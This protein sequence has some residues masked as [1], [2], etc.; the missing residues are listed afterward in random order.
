MC[1]FPL[2]VR[3]DFLPICSWPRKE[4]HSCWEKPFSARD[5]SNNG[6]DQEGQV[7]LWTISSWYDRKWGPGS[8]LGY[9]GRE[10]GSP[11]SLWLSR[12][13]TRMN[14]WWHT[15]D[16]NSQQKGMVAP[17]P[18]PTVGEGPQVNGQGQEVTPHS[19]G[20]EH[21]YIT[22]KEWELGAGRRQSCLRGTLTMTS[23]LE[24]LCAAG[25]SCSKK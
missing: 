21:P 3:R 25:S 7:C 5:L 17:E 12:S 4:S 19:P 8:S 16:G 13:R 6:V 10:A 22:Q 24:S 14:R 20:P 11:G 23:S 9:Q 1:T 2:A 15:N 18:R